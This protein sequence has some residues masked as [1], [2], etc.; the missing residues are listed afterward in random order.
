[1]T[2]LIWIQLAIV[3]TATELYRDAAA[4]AAG[5]GAKKTR[6]IS[7]NTMRQLR[8]KVECCCRDICRV[9]G[10]KLFGDFF[11]LLDVMMRGLMTARGCS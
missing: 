5:R 1:M 3:T 6:E 4:A 9:S 11:K 7:N 10:V 2:A 8:P